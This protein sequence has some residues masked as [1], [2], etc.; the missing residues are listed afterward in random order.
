MKTKNRIVALSVS[1]SILLSLLI[2][3][4]IPTV[5]LAS[6]ET[7]Y[8]SSAE[9]LLELSKKCSYDAW[10]T[11]K[12]VVLTADISLDGV[13][14]API[15]TFNGVFDGQ[16]HTISGLNISGA[17]SPVGLFSSLEKAGV[18]KNLTVKGAIVPNGD[19][20]YVGG[21]V[22]INSG[23]IEGSVFVGTVIGSSD[24]GGIAGLNKVSG[25][26]SECAVEGEI[27]GE[28]RTGGIAGSNEGLISSC[29]SEAKV[30]TISVTPS[31]SLD[32]INIS[33]TLDITKIPSLNNMTMS[34]TGGICG[35][36]TGI[37]IGCENNGDVGYPHIG[38]NVGGIIGR[39]SGH[40]VGNKNNADINGRKDVGGI[41]GQIEPHISYDLSEDLLLSLK[42]ELDKLEVAVNGALGSTGD[43]IP[44]ISTRLDTILDNLKGATSSLDKIINDGS[45]YGN[46]LIGEV[47]RVSEVVGE[48]ISQLSGI[49][50]ELPE[51]SKLLGDS[52]SE[53]EA[54]LK[55]LE[56]FSSISQDMLNDIIGACDDISKAFSFLTESI[57][58]INASIGMLESSITVND[59]D[60]L[61]SSLEQIADGISEFV[62]ATDGFTS[63]LNGAVDILQN[64]PWMDDAVN[65]V[66][67]LVDI[68]GEIS[69]SMSK[70]YDAT[71][72]IDE[73]IDIYWSKF[74][75][76]GD[77]IA[78][79]IGHFADMTDSLADAMELIDGGIG[80][81]SEGFEMLFGSV[82]AEDSDAMNEAIAKIGEGAD[83][84][85]DGAVKMGEA[86]SEI[87]E[88]VKG[89]DENSELGETVSVLIDAI[90][91]IAEYG[92]GASEAIVTLGSGLS[93]ALN[94]LKIDFD[95]IKNGGALIISGVGDI[96][97]SINKM[98]DAIR[99][100]SDGMAAL[101]TAITAVNEAVIIKDEAKLSSSLD[102][103]YLALGEIIDS[104][105]EM[106]V[107]LDQ[108]T[109]TLSEAIVW[110]E[111]LTLAVGGITAAMNEM[112][113]AL[114]KV[115]DGVD[116][117][118]ASI[119][120]DPAVA[121]S[122]LRL[123][124]EGLSF[125]M[126][127]SSSI[128]DC[129]N[130]ISDA[131]VKINSG[132]D[133]LNGAITDLKECI[134]KMRDA[135]GNVSSI[136]E[137]V[138]LLVGYLNGVD[139]VQL[140]T[141]PDSITATANQLFIHL[142]AIEN[143]I[144]LLN[145]EISGLGSELVGQLGIINEIF[146]NLSDNIVNIIYSLNDGS[147]IDNNV[148]EAEIDTVT[149]G[150]LFSCINYGN[151]FGDINVGG[152]GG[153]MGLEYALDPEDDMSG[154]LTVTQKKQYRLK[155]VIHACQNEGNVTSKYDCAGG[156]TGKMDLGLIYGCEAYCNVE[157]QSG[158]YVGG[159]AGITAGLISQCFTK[160]SL[161]GD[162]Y[163]GGIVGSGVSESY[164]GDSSMVRNCYSM[165]EIKRYTQYAGAISGANIGEYSENLFVS[166]SLAG[167]DRISYLG[168]AEPI[169]FEDLIKRRNIPDKFHRFTLEFVADGNILH[170]IEFEYGSSFDTS[171]FPE[172]P[173][174]AGYYGY[175]DMLSLENLVFDTTVS[176][177][178]KPYI[179]AIGSEEKRENDREIFFVQGDFI[180][181]ENISLKEGCDTTELSLVEKFFTED[182]LV[183]SWILT[184]PKDN[185]A[186]NN[187]HFLPNNEHAR[188]F[189]KIDGIWQEA[190]TA[191]FGSYLAFDVSG[192]VI[193]IAV[194]EHS[195]KLMP[196]ILLLAGAFIILI[197]VIVV[198]VVVRRK[199][200]KGNPSS[201]KE[202]KR[203]E[204]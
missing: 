107:V 93:S 30:N 69:I 119:T 36:S 38:Y 91:D 178:Y 146:G 158:S 29:K 99:Q 28:N 2:P 25:S 18:I 110:S 11:G 124:R 193:E 76:T 175:W 149:Q 144:K 12:T 32:E 81:T 4:L 34:D 201:N 58:R 35:Y 27:L 102:S 147:F 115:Q 197:S 22:G 184:I 5:A 59:K 15:A 202:K 80:K 79:A 113:G 47:N 66:N 21:I 46:D 13:D 131:L 24:I 98:K 100:M 49:T 159:I 185:L 161:Y 87:S 127:A 140:P 85:I 77:S 8:I 134:G 108:I 43:G 103:L 176:V 6:E 67:Q 89:L 53:L 82:K 88:T 31:L 61:E 152:I 95:G 151:V 42:T 177:V 195:I 118:R 105:V 92:A 145:A 169:S 109:D 136:C 186:V 171:V 63:A 128:K 48:V 86:L 41:V 170:S 84:L 199:K 174:K 156:I 168:K 121:A 90:G 96:S 3:L 50:D 39:N 71:I 189:I 148:N 114:V 182:Q 162:K 135:M 153:T 44:G 94:N 196:L 62:K 139:P 167:I 1:I 97:D 116:L 191:Q 120:F 129:F 51:L 181:G 75:E 173:E 203:S 37:V 154:E 9:D 14:F 112:T 70:I 26:I 126:H 163:I 132:S 183:E 190:Q 137:K 204:A 179:T 78:T 7:I 141:L 101:D 72:E 73:N 68:F 165:V 166:D 40:L 74:E 117:L 54:A 157:S 23:R 56:S 133:A 138:G 172:I 64:I 104:T 160:S 16:R 83:M 164:S 123:I 106:S 20:G 200:N 187:I 155:A 194:V 125:M 10:S 198:C 192:D 180:E 122:G 60:S 188:I 19:K 150:K 17:Y 33:L 130:H 52:L 65:E 45:R 143:E 55:N 111:E 142:L 57:R